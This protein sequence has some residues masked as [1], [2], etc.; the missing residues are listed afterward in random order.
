MPKHEE[1]IVCFWNLIFSMSKGTGE[2]LIR[3]THLYVGEI[4]NN[5]Y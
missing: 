5:M 3:E 4:P 2:K 1:F